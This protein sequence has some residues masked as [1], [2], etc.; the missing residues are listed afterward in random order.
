MLAARYR[1]ETTEFTSKAV[2]FQ[3]ILA[4]V[5]SDPVNLSRFFVYRVYRDALGDERAGAI[6]DPNYAPFEE[7][8]AALRADPSTIQ[9]LKRQATTSTTAFRWF[10]DIAG[11]DGVLLK[12]DSV[13]TAAFKAAVAGLS[14]NGLYSVKRRESS[15]RRSSSSRA[16]RERQ[17]EKTFERPHHRNSVPADSEPLPATSASSR[18]SWIWCLIVLGIIALIMW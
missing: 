11:R 7:V 14:Q 10:G 3:R 9:S 8:A 15:G 12:G 1:I 13:A 5:S 4:K 17:A 16:L 6:T 2:I 18:V